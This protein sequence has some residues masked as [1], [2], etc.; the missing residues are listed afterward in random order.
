MQKELEMVKAGANA[1]GLRLIGDRFVGYR[2]VPHDDAADFA[3]KMLVL[4]AED[5]GHL[6]AWCEKNK[7]AD[8]SA[9][10][11]NSRA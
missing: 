9:E 7:D 6:N 4:A 11:W 8:Y 2:F 10:A 5:G 3:N 1:V